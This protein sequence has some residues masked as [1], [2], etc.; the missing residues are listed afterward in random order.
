MSTKLWSDL[1][2]NE[3]R[4]EFL[5]QGRGYTTGIM[6]MT[7]EVDT[8]QAYRALSKLQAQNEM[9]K[10]A[11]ERLRGTIQYNRDSMDVHQLRDYCTHACSAALESLKSTSDNPS[12]ED[13]SAKP[14]V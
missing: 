5:E 13:D 2:T 3:E 9:M 7:V 11:L 1:N 8:A 12:K 4:A 6:A 14:K 10:T